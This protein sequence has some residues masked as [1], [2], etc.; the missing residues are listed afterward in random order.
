M[1]KDVALNTEEK[2]LLYNMSREDLGKLVMMEES[3]G[4]SV[5]LDLVNKIIDQEKNIF[6]GEKAYTAE[7]LYYLHAYSN[8]GIAKLISLM[9]II[10]GAKKELHARDDKGEKKDES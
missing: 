7:R 6:F 9:R 10:V 1:K 2:V 5:V 8:G 4:F 3:K